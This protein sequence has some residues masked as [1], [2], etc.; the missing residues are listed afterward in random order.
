VAG[1]SP[2]K[3]LRYRDVQKINLTEWYPYT[4]AFK[5]TT[6]TLLL[7][8]FNFSELNNKKLTVARETA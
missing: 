7:Q 1:G 8:F 4:S 5:S 6:R 2:P 3:E